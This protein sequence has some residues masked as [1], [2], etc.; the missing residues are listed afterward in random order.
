MTRFSRFTSILLVIASALSGCAQFESMGGTNALT[1]LLTQQL[2]VTTNQATGGTGSVPPLQASQIAAAETSAR[3]CAA[4]RYRRRR[5][6][7]GRLLRERPAGQ[8]TSGG[9][10]AGPEMSMPEA[11]LR[12]WSPAPTTGTRLQGARG[13]AR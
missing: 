6:G 13:S 8:G 2:G 12:P 11:R 5:I 4:R 3:L 10:A 7:S 1:S 9:K